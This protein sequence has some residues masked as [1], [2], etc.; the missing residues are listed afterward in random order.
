M[1]MIKIDFQEPNNQA[2]TDWKAQCHSAQQ[3]HN[4]KIALGQHPEVNARIYKGEDYNIKFTVY[5]NRDSPFS[6]KCAFCESDVLANQPGD[7]EHYR[8]KAEVKD[9][10]NKD[11][12]VVIDEVLQRHPGYFWLAYDWTNLLPSCRDCNARTKAKTKGEFIGK[13][14]LFPVRDFRAVIPGQHAREVPMIINPVFVDPIDHIWIDNLGIVHAHTP[15]G[16]ATI[17]ILGLNKREGL[18][19]ARKDTYDQVKDKMKVYISSLQNEGSNLERLREQLDLIKK[20]RKP[21]SLAAIQ[22]ME[23][24]VAEQEELVKKLRN[25]TDN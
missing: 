1:S 9:E 14:T 7:I 13:G 15:E 5:F 18:I 6:G 23:D 8:P 25:M 12:M 10:D 22:A 20:G 3:R 2:W 19:T 16:K 24:A 21:Y 11:V 17:E 4:E